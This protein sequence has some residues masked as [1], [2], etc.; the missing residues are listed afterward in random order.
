MTLC[1]VICWAKQRWIW[2]TSRSA[3]YLRQQMCI[4]YFQ[5]VS[6]VNTTIFR[7]KFH[8]NL[9]WFWYKNKKKTIHKAATT[10][11]NLDFITVWSTNRFAAFVNIFSYHRFVHVGLTIRKCCSRALRVSASNGVLW[12]L[13]SR[14]QVRW[15]RYI[16]HIH[17]AHVKS[18]VVF[19]LICVLNWKTAEAVW[20]NKIHRLT[21]KICCCVITLH[22]LSPFIGFWNSLENKFAKFWHVDKKK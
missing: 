22:H 17:T 14:T 18:S 9:V 2:C 15:Q 13:G 21:W 19:F 20:S 4:V 11:R 16:T 3:N 1:A 7:P 5:C 10:S 8:Q 6:R 12:T